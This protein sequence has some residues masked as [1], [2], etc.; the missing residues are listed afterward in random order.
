MKRL[1]VEHCKRKIKIK[2]KSLDKKIFMSQK[3]N[4]INLFNIVLDN[5]EINDINL[6][7]RITDCE[8]LLTKGNVIGDASYTY[9]KKKHIIVLTPNLIED[10]HN[11]YIHDLELSIIHELSHLYDFY[12]LS[13]YKKI[14][15]NP[16][17]DKNKTEEDAIFELGYFFWTEFN[18]YRECFKFEKEFDYH[19]TFQIINK[20]HEIK[21][22]DKLIKKLFKEEDSNVFNEAEEYKKIIDSFIYYFARYLAGIIF[23]KKKYYKYSEKNLASKEYK[24]I[25]KLDYGLSIRIVKMFSNRYGK[26]Y[27]K[28]IYNIGSYILKNIYNDF[29]I[30]LKKINKKICYLKELD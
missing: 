29:G 23:G 11:G 26:Y 5:M 21:E 8:T 16:Y 27:Y 20:I 15:F 1:K 3:D 19:T 24:K 28:R 2:N 30:F 25:E 13:K 9:R 6:E 17:V 12:M 4:I 22:K 14:K 18:A 7:I 10:Y